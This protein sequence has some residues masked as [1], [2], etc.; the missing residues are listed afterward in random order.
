MS[1]TFAVTGA[2]FEAVFETKIEPFIETR[3][4]IK[5]RAL[6]SYFFV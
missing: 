5:I 1:N 2:V 6:L 4:A 3:T